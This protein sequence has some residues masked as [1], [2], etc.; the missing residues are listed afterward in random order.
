M[1]ISMAVGSNI[2]CHYPNTVVRNTKLR[3]MPKV[4]Q[5]IAN[6]Q[7]NFMLKNSKS[8]LYESILESIS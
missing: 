3:S 8:P 1:V 2:K 6:P 4:S 7:Q 5:L